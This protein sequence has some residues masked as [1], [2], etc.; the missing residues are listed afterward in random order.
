MNINDI[1]NIECRKKY[2]KLR[3][4]DYI[5]KGDFIKVVEYVFSEKEMKRYSETELEARALLDIKRGA[6]REKMIEVPCEYIGRKVGDDTH[7]TM[8]PPIFR[9]KEN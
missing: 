1:K 5:K 4:Q 3:P 7:L 8:P 9:K 6:G 2:R